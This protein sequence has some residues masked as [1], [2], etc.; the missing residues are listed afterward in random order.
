ML[1]FIFLSIPSLRLSSLSPSQELS[2]FERKLLGALCG[3]FHSRNSAPV[4]SFFPLVMDF[5]GVNNRYGQVAVP[6]FLEHLC[7]RAP[8]LSDIVKHKFLTQLQCSVCRWVS[9]RVCRDVS[10]K[11]YIPPDRKQFT[12]NELVD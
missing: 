4:S 12:L 5:N 10:L 9:Q 2:D 6:D 1:L 7:A 3:I 11:L 8:N